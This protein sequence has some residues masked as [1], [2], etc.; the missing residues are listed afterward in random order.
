MKLKK[1]D[2]YLDVS[3]EEVEGL[4]RRRVKAFP[5]RLE[6]SRESTIFVE[7]HPLIFQNVLRL[8]LLHNV[9]FNDVCY[10]STDKRSA[11]KI[12]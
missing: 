10:Y 2:H 6:G 8:R 5:R 1:P 3:P 12:H 4:K 11:W 9:E 7:V